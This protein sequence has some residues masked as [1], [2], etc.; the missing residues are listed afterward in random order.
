MKL[1]MISGDRSVMQGKMGA[2]WYTLQELRKHFDRI[3]IICP[4][5]SEE[6][7]HVSESGHRFGHPVENGADVFF[8]PCPHG[9]WF[10][11]FWIVRKGKALLHEFRHDTMTVHDYPPFYNGI[12]AKMLHKKTRIPYATEIHHIV[13]VPKAADLSE[14]IGREMTRWLLPYITRTASAVRTV[15]H[16][17]ALQV[18][19]FGVPRQK[20][21]VL[22][23]F[24]LD[25]EI[26]STAAKPPVSY[27]I[28]FCG[29]LVSNKGLPELLHAVALMPSVRLLVIGDGPE[30]L[31]MEQK[32]DELGIANRVTF[33]GWLP[34]QESVSGA[35]QTARIFVMN[36]KSE[37]G[38]RVAL[39]AMAC[40]LPIVTTKVGIMPDIISNGVNGIFTTGDSKDLVRKIS[41]LLGDEEQMKAMSKEAKKV[42]DVYERGTLI[43]QYADFL[44]HLVP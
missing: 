7:V 40:G 11:P 36:S 34:T 13:G 20:V 24:Y 12:G 1:L 21:H 31:R 5:V 37:G 4:R 43:A 42:L 16:T 15:N 18:A 29:R 6:S 17:V 33:L 28:S 25:K 44:K 10:Q 19:H 39:E 27:D 9:L 26:L 35:I 30:R 32:V 14:V 3:D 41:A 2:F 8:H 23:S 38:P 22:S